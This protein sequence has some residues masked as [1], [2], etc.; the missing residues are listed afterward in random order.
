LGKIRNY[1]NSKSCVIFSDHYIGMFNSIAYERF[2]MN[3]KRNGFTSMK[4]VKSKR[5]MTVR[6]STQEE[7]QID[8]ANNTCGIE[9][10]QIEEVDE[11][12]GVIEGYDTL[13]VDS[14]NDTFN[15]S[16]EMLG[17]A[18]IVDEVN[19]NIV[20]QDHQILKLKTMLKFLE[21]GKKKQVKKFEKQII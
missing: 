20:H 1:Y 13:Y 5:Y 7:E 4:R 19:L 2:G 17:P 18:P 15:N 16:N 3:T 21:S 11:S 14:S 9:S 6:T 8:D 10:N 12:Q